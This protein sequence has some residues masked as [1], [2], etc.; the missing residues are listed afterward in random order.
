MG[1]ILWSD[2]PYGVFTFILITLVLGG[3][4]AWATGR[5]IAKTWR[6]IATLAP[7][8]VCLAAAVRFLHYALYGE[9]L[10]SVPLFVTALIWMILV[11]ALGYRAMRATQMATQYS[12][13][14]LARERKWLNQRALDGQTFVFFKV[15]L[16][17]K[18]E[19]IGLQGGIAFCRWRQGGPGARNLWE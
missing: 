13:A 12:R 2:S 17:Q 3:A 11:G 18:Q 14:E 4:G 7:Y 1:D 9:P 5:A 19:S 16:D 6:P 10:L 15:T 8:M